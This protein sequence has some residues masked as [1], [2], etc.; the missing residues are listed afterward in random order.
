MVAITFPFHKYLD[1]GNELLIEKESDLRFAIDFS[2]FWEDHKI[3][4]VIGGLGLYGKYWIERLTQHQLY[5]R[6]LMDRPHKCREL[7]GYRQN[8]ASKAYREHKAA[9]GNKNWNSFVDR[10]IR[11]QKDQVI[12]IHEEADHYREQNQDCRRVRRNRYWKRLRKV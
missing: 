2:T 8:Y 5:P 7:Y 9:G 4:K 11:L 1:P 12:V 6:P 10:G 3:C